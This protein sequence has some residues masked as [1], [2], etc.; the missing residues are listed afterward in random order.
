MADLKLGASGSDVKK[1]QQT[2]NNLF[3]ASVVE[4]NGDYDEETR[5]KV[6]ELQEKLDIGKSSGEADSATLKAFAK[7][8]EPKNY[9]ELGPVE[10]YLDAQE[11]ANLYDA[12]RVIAAKTLGPLI[13]MAKQFRVAWQAHDDA[14]SNHYF[15]S[16]VLD[17]VTG[18][19]FPSAST[20][21]LVEA[22]AKDI[23]SE[24]RNGTLTAASFADKSGIIRNGFAELDQ[25]RDE[26]FDGATDF[27]DTMEKTATACGE[28]VDVLM[29]VAM[30]GRSTTQQAV[31]A[32][33][34]GA[35]K[36]ALG[37]VIKA[38]K[39]PSYDV[40][41]GVGRTLASGAVN[42]GIKALTKGAVGAKVIEDAEKRA[43]SAAGESVV[44]K[45]VARA[46]VG[47][48]QNMIEEG[49]KGIPGLSD[50]NKK[51]KPEDLASAAAFAFINGAFIKELNGLCK[52]FGENAASKFKLES[53]LPKGTKLDKAAEQG[54]KKVLNKAGL[55][56]VATVMNN[57]EP[58]TK[59]AEVEKK[60][61][62]EIE[63]DSDVKKFV[64]DLSEK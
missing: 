19:S 6:A 17:V 60:M 28:I 43:L 34:A 59:P 7:A 39:T 58:G 9:V 51:M 61:R 49:L 20:A 10:A 30:A 46:F 44:K 27:T 22:A 53:F 35:Y 26:T 13:S 4:E 15:W 21:K 3:Q 2:I 5:D 63:G 38:S 50:P 62:A 1:L 14:R 12:T 23:E 48:A 25:Y 18:A 55:Q 31:G 24:A 11:M 56:A 47:G 45:F 57:I 64:K 40:K 37:E 33:T 42:A 52:V 8:L 41:M 16:N 32:G 54:L 29:T 36:A